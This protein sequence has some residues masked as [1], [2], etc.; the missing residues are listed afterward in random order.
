VNPHRLLHA[1]L[2]EEPANALTAL[3][4]LRQ[5]LDQLEHEHALALRQ[6]GRTWSDIA[7]LLGI[8]RQATRER[9]MHWDPTQT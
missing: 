9:Y 1:A 5:L 3:L 8:T 6:R 7:R 4:E 2:H